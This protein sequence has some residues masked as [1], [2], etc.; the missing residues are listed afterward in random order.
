M[1]SCC[2]FYVL[3]L[4]T[5]ITPWTFICSCVQWLRARAFKAPKASLKVALT[6]NPLVFL[7]RSDCLL[8][9]Q[10]L[11]SSFK[12][13]GSS[14]PPR[15]S[16]RAAFNI[17]AP[18]SWRQSERAP[19]RERITAACSCASAQLVMGFLRGHFKVSR[20]FPF[21]I[22]WKDIWRWICCEHW[23]TLKKWRI[24]WLLKNNYRWDD[25]KSIYLSLHVPE[26]TV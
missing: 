23:H 16:S 5:P 6:V 18:S 14:A 20:V 19:H 10:S 12:R 1:F 15:C 22:K 25:W 8:V 2:I 21:R 4:Q 7:H 13:W 3:T 26:A 9:E 24:A 17:P 11:S